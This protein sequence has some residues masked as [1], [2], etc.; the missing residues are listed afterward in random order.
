MT[1]SNDEIRQLERSLSTFLNRQLQH[2]CVSH[3]LKTGGV[4]A[5]LQSRIRNA[6]IE[7]YTLDPPTFR[8][9]QSTIRSIARAPAGYTPQPNMSSSQGGN[10]AYGYNLG[11]PSFETPGSTRF[12]FTGGT[13]HPPP[14]LGSYGSSSAPSSGTLD[15]YKNHLPSLREI[16]FKPSPFYSVISRI[17]DVLTCDVMTQHRN[18][19]HMSIKVCEYASLVNLVD[20]SY[21]IMVFCASD[22]TGVQDIAF[23]HQ[24]EFKVNGGEVKANLRGLK[25][26]PGTTRPVDITDLLRVK[27]SNYNNNVE[28]TYA[29]TTKKFYLT[30]Y[31]CQMVSVEDL[32][33]KIRGK[34]IAKHAVIKEMDKKANDPD[35][36]ATS[37]VLSLKCP[38]S[39]TRLRTPCRSVLCNH[40]QCFDASSYLQLQEQGPQWICPICN[41]SA[42]FDSLAIDEYVKDILDKTTDS[43]EQVTIEPNGQWMTPSTKALPQRSRVSGADTGIHV[44]DDVSVVADKPSNLNGTSHAYSTP[45]R[46]FAGNGLI[47]S[48]SKEP[49]GA[50]TSNGKKRPAAEVIDLT[51]SSD[52]DDSPLVRP[53][54][55]QNVGSSAGA[56]SYNGFHTG[57][58]P[59][60]HY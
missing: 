49:L 7:N 56:S 15:Y 12:Q 35:V 17:G 28:F 27:P 9:I 18:T 4:K 51:L 1:S 13:H 39:Y 23:P 54:K 8:Q 53:V 33:T 40:I 43:I 2:I 41:K 6:L 59:A 29:L 46:A 32:V 16:Q 5:E 55:R 52:E 26:K 24:S 21:R 3:G 10:H 11:K 22:N 44:V 14:P 47:S 25:G 48:G 20:K 58:P 38:L 57:R 30:T 37:T 34:K 36:V 19:I 42:L 31:L 45:P 50:P 60:S